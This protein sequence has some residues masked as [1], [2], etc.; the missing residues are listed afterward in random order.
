[1]KLERTQGKESSDRTG[2]KSISLRG[3]QCRKVTEGSSAVCLE[4]VLWWGILSVWSKVAEA[5]WHGQFQI[6]HHCG[7]GQEGSSTQGQRPG[8][9]VFLFGASSRNKIQFTF[10][11][12]FIFLQAQYTLQIFPNCMFWTLRLLDLSVTCKFLFLLSFDNKELCSLLN[13]RFKSPAVC[14]EMGRY[15]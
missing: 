8:K 9:V 14:P 4:S 11:S 15:R 6:K 3:G 13:G 7:C 2:R 12:S 5:A 1:M 10:F